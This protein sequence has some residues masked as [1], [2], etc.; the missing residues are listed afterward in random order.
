M[1]SKAAFKV[2]ALDAGTGETVYFDKSDLPRDDYAIL[3]ASSSIPVL[4]KP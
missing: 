1:D 2:V 4:C 3:K